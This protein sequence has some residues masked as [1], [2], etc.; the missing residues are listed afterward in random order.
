MYVCMCACACAYVCMCVH[1][2]VCTCVPVCMYCVHM[3]LGQRKTDG[4]V[5]RVLSTFL[6][7]YYFLCGRAHMCHSAAVE[8]KGQPQ[9][10][11]LLS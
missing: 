1:V 3:S 10:S 8:L 11:V 5:P 4:G 9:G 6:K 7:N 2:L